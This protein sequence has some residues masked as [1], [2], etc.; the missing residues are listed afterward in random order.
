MPTGSATVPDLVTP[1]WD[2]APAPEARTL[3]TI[4]SSYGLF[5]GGDFVDPVDGGRLT[6]VDP[7]T[8]DALA[9]IGEAGPGDVDRAV[10]AARRAFTRWSKLPGAERGKYLFRIARAAAGALPRAGRARVDRQRQAD[11]RDP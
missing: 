7:S 11:P 6:T 1:S 9:E 5:I 3:A 8:G 4:R 10:K 2:Y